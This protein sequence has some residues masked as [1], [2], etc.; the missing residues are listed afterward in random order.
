MRIIAADS[1]GAILEKGYEPVC[2]VGTAAVLV[3]PPYRSPSVTLWKPFEYNLD[4]RKPILNELSFC[5]ELFKE[6]GAD[7]IHLDISLGGINLFDLDAK[8]LANYKI[9]PK[10]RKVLENLVPKLKNVAKSFNG[11]KIL[12][13][14]KESSAVRIAELT[15]GIYGLL[16]V[17][18]K[19]VNEEREKVFY[20]LP[21]EC[22][23]LVS[24][25]HLTIRSLKAS[26]FD[27]S[28]TVDLPRD[29]LNIVELLEYPN[30]IASGFR[31]IELR[32]QGS[33]GVS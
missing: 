9:S 30:P 15:A 16:Y 3:E 12:L 24:K 21:R 18:S 29:I 31:V 17:I 23:I 11:I 10:G 33:N 7:V 25:T 20:G 6:H 22:S 27:I 4:E 28:V 13:I 14:G 32:R 2:I 1:G 26:E 8:R 19:F 5:L